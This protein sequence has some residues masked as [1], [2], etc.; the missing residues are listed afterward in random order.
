MRQFFVGAICA[1]SMAAVCAQAVV[2]PNANL[3]ADG[4]PAIPQTIADRVAQYT[5][6]RGHGFIGWH[7]VERSMLVR[8]REQ[9][10][11]MAQ[12]YWLKAPGGKLERITD[13][14]DNVSSASFAP[15]GGQF[16]V[17][18]RDAG[19]NE[20]TQIFRMDLD[21]RKS[22]LLSSADERSGYTW[23]RAGDRVLLHA[24][25]LDKTAQG[26]SRTEVRTVL[27]LVDAGAIVIPR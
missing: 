27:S 10:A 6:F 2:V 4:I 1:L 12:I 11:N 21:T 26:G 15:R 16:I 23:T 14:A 25:P 17:Y 24:V 8:H 13:F 7:P 22:T 20:A 18:G 19:G 3:L 5:E 9:G